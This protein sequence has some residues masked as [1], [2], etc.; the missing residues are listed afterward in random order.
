MRTKSA[1]LGLSFSW[2][3]LPTTQMHFPSEGLR[4]WPVQALEVP[5][6]RFRSASFV[7]R[8]LRSSS[9]LYS[10]SVAPSV[11]YLV[12]AAGAAAAAAARRRR[13]CDSI[14]ENYACTLRVHGVRK[15][16]I[17][18]TPTHPGVHTDRPTHSYTLRYTPGLPPA[19]RRQLR[20]VTRC[21]TKTLP[22]SSRYDKIQNVAVFPLRGYR[23]SRFLSR[24]WPSRGSTVESTPVNDKSARGRR[25]AHRENVRRRRQVRPVGEE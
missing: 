2:S 10:P 17:K 9:C 16:V 5:R 25:R 20:C 23:G 14:R 8:P 4:S 18:T 24:G 6:L 19:H 11:R 13:K 12:A 3:H 21:G 22:F 1:L 7:Q 15:Q